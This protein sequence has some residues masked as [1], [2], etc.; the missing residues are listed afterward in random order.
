MRLDGNVNVVVTETLGVMK[1]L[2]G[3]SLVVENPAVTRFASF[4]FA[5]VTESELARGGQVAFVGGNLG[6]GTG[7]GQSGV[8]F[9]AAPSLS[10]SIIPWALAQTT[11]TSSPV[12]DTN[13][14]NPDTL[15]TYGVNGVAPLTTFTDD[16]F[17]SSTANVRL[18]TAN[19]PSG[20]S[21]AN[22][23]L[24]DTGGSLTLTS[25]LM[26]TSG[27]LFNRAVGGSIAGSGAIT[28]T[29]RL[30]LSSSQ[31]LTID[32]PISAAHLSKGGN[33]SVTI[34]G[35]VSLGAN[36]LISVNA[37]TLTFGSLAS[38][39]PASGAVTY[40]VSKGATLENIPGAITGELRGT[41]TVNGPVYHCVRQ[42]HCRQTRWLVAWPTAIRPA[43]SL[44]PAR[45]LCKAEPSSA[46]M[47]AASSVANTPSPRSTVRRSISAES[48]RRT[49]SSFSRN[50]FC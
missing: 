1:P 21:T 23:L 44:S 29:G 35:S 18:T 17:V 32:A 49:P 10:D 46:L 31:P 13:T 27:A 8:T 34:N 14:T 47:S 3:Q 28:A 16:S 45:S 9:T 4:A 40:Q 15:A 11:Y 5:S 24:I 2:A 38:V 36:P 48:L 33:S 6:A 37:G 42:H 7:A 22:S 41:G 39:T 12:A 43:C 26:L 20:V 30:Y 19:A 50:R 25:P